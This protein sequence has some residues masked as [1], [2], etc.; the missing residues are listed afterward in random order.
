MLRI[1][2]V[3]M[4]CCVAVGRVAKEV[5]R[6]DGSLADQLRRAMASVALNLSEGSCSQGRNRNARYFNAMGSA[7]EVSTALEAVATDALL[8]WLE[9]FLVTG[10]APPA[11]R[12]RRVAGDVLRVN[13]PPA[14]AVAM[15][16][17]W[18]R[19]AANLTQGE[20]AKRA[21][22]SQQQIA[23]LERPG[24]NPTIATLAKVADAL[25]V[26]LDVGFTR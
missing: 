5:A 8:G 7:A 22:V 2:S 17:R 12:A 24:E 18:A 14:L 1:Q 4:E 20:L 16:I 3:A 10:D 26:R 6:S 21:H 11:P 25:H 23:K 9:A 15:E 13:V 19:L